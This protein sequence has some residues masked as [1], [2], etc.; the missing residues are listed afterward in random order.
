MVE[1]WGRGPRGPSTLL[2][3]IPS[4]VEGWRALVVGFGIA[5]GAD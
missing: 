1:G 4:N 3:A 2:K 5:P